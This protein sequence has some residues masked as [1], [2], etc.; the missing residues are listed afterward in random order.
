MPGRWRCRECGHCKYATASNGA[1]DKGLR[2]ARF[3]GAIR[4][5]A[6]WAIIAAAAYLN[7]HATA[8]LGETIP[9]IHLFEQNCSGCHNNRGDAAPGA[10]QAPNLTTLQ[11]MTP[12]RIYTAIT[13]RSEERRVR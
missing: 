10:G 1:G 9:G 11:S 13:T 5:S 3:T 8:A 7:L 4:D 6:Q 12:E 2:M